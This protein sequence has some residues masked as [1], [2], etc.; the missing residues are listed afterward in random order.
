MKNRI[1]RLENYV[2]T[3]NNKPEVQPAG[4]ELNLSKESFHELFNTELPRESLWHE[5]EQTKRDSLV[6]SLFYTNEQSTEEAYKYLVDELLTCFVN[7]LRR[8]RKEEDELGTCARDLKTHPELRL[9][10]EDELT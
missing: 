5:L 4:I 3:N 7:V 9:L 2:K 8:I 10:I 6:H 1:A